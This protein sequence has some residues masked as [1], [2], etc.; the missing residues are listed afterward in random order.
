MNERPEN[1]IE[2]RFE[3]GGSLAPP[4][5]IGR[6]VRFGLGV[7]L[8]S[9]FYSVVR[10]GWSALVSTTRPSDWTWWAFMAV[11]F[12]LLPYVVNIGFTRNWKRAPQLVLGAALALAIVADLA[13]WGTWWAPPLGALVWTWLAYFS[14]HLGGSFLVSALIATPGCEMRAFPHL[15]ARI[16]G[17]ET[18]AHHCPGFIDS[19]DRW[20]GRRR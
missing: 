19:V 20:E 16:I 18:R 17:R 2:T 10:Y 13:F 6:A 3:S 9:A 7:W 4:R 11:A 15:R 12:W 8:L 5:W 14:G 1:P